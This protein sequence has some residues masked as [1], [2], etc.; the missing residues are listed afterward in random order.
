MFQREFRHN[1]AHRQAIRQR[2]HLSSWAAGWTLCH[3]NTVWHWG[4]HG[5]VTNTDTVHV[6]KLKDCPGCALFDSIRMFWDPCSNASCCWIG[7]HNWCHQACRPSVPF[8]GSSLYS[9]TLFCSSCTVAPLVDDVI[10]SVL[11]KVPDCALS[12]AQVLSCDPTGTTSQV[13]N[14]KMSNGR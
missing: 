8:G 10:N 13:E 11:L 12:G 14:E 7:L 2:Y 1:P 5:T 9:L 4:M 3:S 6:F